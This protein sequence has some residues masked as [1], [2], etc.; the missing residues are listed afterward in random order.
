MPR[1]SICH[2]RLAAG[3]RCPSDGVAVSSTGWSEF[4]G[5]APPGYPDAQVLGV[6]GFA[7]TWNVPWQD[8]F[9]ALKWSRRTSPAVHKIFSHEAEM[10]ELAGEALAPKLLERGILE[11]RPYLLLESLQSNRGTLGAFLDG[12]NEPLSDA[13][14][15]DLARLLVGHLGRL[16]SHNVLHQD[17][18]PENL[19]LLPNAVRFL[20]FGLSRRADAIEMHSQ[21]I[22][23][24]YAAPERLRGDVGD[25]ASDIYSLGVVLYEV[26]TLRLPFVSESMSVEFEHM[27]SKPPTPS[28]FAPIS[29]EMDSLLVDC[30]AK[31]PEQRPSIEQ[32]LERLDEQPAA[33]VSSVSRETQVYREARVVYLLVASGLTLA[34]TKVDVLA[35]AH[36]AIVVY[37]QGGELLLAWYADTNRNAIQEGESLGTILERVGAKDVC[38]HLDDVQMLRRAGQH[39]VLY[40]A[41]IDNV[42][43]WRVG[44][45]GAGIARSKPLS[46]RRVVELGDTQLIGRAQELQA[47][48]DAI[49][50]VMQQRRPEI[51]TLVGP[52]G[53]GKSRLLREL[54]EA[55]AER[56]PEATLLKLQLDT[57]LL[58]EL[59]HGEML[60]D[61]ASFGP[62][63]VLVDDLL[64]HSNEELDSLEYAC[65]DA[66][67]RPIVLVGCAPQDVQVQRPSWGRRAARHTE[68]TL[69]L[70]TASDSC[71]LLEALL[72]PA[73]YIPQEALDLLVGIADGLPQGI[74]DLAISL[75]RDGYLITD[76]LG[77][78]RLDAAR[79]VASPDHSM[80]GWLAEACIEGVPESMAQLIGACALLPRAFSASEVLAL[81]DDL[82]NS[83]SFPDVPMGLLFWWNQSVLTCDDDLFAFDSP[84]LK[85][86]LAS[87]VPTET[88][89]RWHR[90]ALR[91]WERECKR[92]GEHAMQRIAIHARLCGE[93]R[94]AGLAYVAL[95]LDAQRCHRPVDAERFYR[96]ALHQLPEDED[97]L[98]LEALKGCGWAGY[99]IDKAMEAVGA[100]D[101]A[102]ALARRLEDNR[103]VALCLLESATALDWAQRF[104]ESRDRV[105]DAETFGEHAHD[106]IVDLRLNLGRGRS[107][108]RSGEH[109]IAIP[110]LV[111]A[112]ETA[113]ALGD[114]D[115]RV[116]ALMLLGPALVVDGRVAAA[117]A[118]FQDLIDLCHSANDKLHLCATYGNR[119]FLRSAMQDTEGA[120]DDLREAVRLARQVGHPGPERVAT[121]NLAED[122]YWSG[123]DDKEALELARRSQDLATRFLSEAVVEDGLLVGR[124]LVALGRVK[125]AKRQLDACAATLPMA[126]WSEGSFC[127]GTMLSLCA[128]PFEPRRWQQLI[129]AARACMGADDLMELRYWRARHAL[130]DKREKDARAWIDECLR[131]VVHCEIWRDRLQHLSELC[132]VF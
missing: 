19:F 29:G 45:S 36:D 110:L 84:V 100:L 106:A 25:C 81:V 70:L 90:A 95:G 33:A 30:L 38:L 87:R 55:S 79:L 132:E 103:E 114:S 4:V 31:N 5:D 1:C 47:A 111:D 2:R 102:A 65:L 42:A 112:A 93:A 108:W 49:E 74:Y 104:S 6:G 113:A 3:A 27:H 9:A 91:Y 52:A 60:L 72:A 115:T 130:E 129:N 83:Q 126:D 63:I 17:L 46:S 37:Y 62:L 43:A 92:E 117:E 99:R 69:S 10:L 61:R 80:G 22:T 75:H 44:V 8:G 21:A 82:P 68:V 73:E 23:P 51:V 97:A 85:A 89:Q 125:E 54:A 118:C 48:L 41:A 76:T 50:R 53:T 88:A 40:G 18:K 35:T 131:D 24:E 94:R 32:L 96:E 39:D 122:L 15:R 16:H 13:V 107:A 59:D 77:R 26:A 101:E 109:S 64:E 7:T 127:F 58:R 121:Y 78:V 14:F 57:G 56:F 98:R 34:I 105:N 128:V 67:D 86:A 71:S 120:R 66:S 11:G 119:M 116:V 12:L 123:E 28:Q 20:D 124:I